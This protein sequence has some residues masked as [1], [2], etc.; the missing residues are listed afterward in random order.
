MSESYPV[1]IAS[2]KYSSMNARVRSNLLAGKSGRSSRRL[3]IHSS[4]IVALQSGRYK[5]L[6]SQTQKEITEAGGIQN[7]GVKQRRHSVHRLLHSEFLIVG[8]QGVKS[9]PATGL[10]FS[11][12]GEDVVGTHTSMRSDLAAGYPPLVEQPHQKSPRNLQQIGRLPGGQFGVHRCQRDRIATGHLVQH[13]PKKPHRLGGNFD[14]FRVGHAESD[15]HGLRRIA[16]LC[17]FR[18]RP[19]CQDDI[20][21][22]DEARRFVFTCPIIHRATPLPTSN[23]RRKRHKR[24]M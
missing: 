19:G 7:V 17:E 10:C 22:A 9:V 12:V 4:W 20:P 11:T 13:L 2:G 5:V 15:W 8:R 23:V 21:F 24:N 18:G 6:I 1:T 3:A 14:R 16:Q